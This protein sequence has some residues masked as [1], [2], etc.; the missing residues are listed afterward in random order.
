L[1]SAQQKR[2]LERLAREHENLRTTLRWFLEEGDTERA[3]RLGGALWWFWWI[4]GYVSEGKE[5]LAQVGA[6]DQQGEAW[7]RAKALH[8]AGTLAALQGRFDETERLCT[9]SLHLFKA[10][11]DARGSIPPLWMLGYI[12]KEQSAYDRARTL[13]EEGL[14]LS[15]HIGHTWG[16]AYSLETLAAV[17]FNQGHYQRAR[18]L[19]EESVA[20]SRKTGDTEGVSRA[21]WLQAL[22]IMAQ[23]DLAQARTLLSRSLALANEVDDKR[24]NAY[25]LVILGYVEIFNGDS[26]WARSFLEGGLSLFRELGD[27]RGIAWAL[28]GL[29]WIALAQGN[30]PAAQK[31]FEES[32]AGLR[33]LGHR[34]FMTLV[35]EGWAAALSAQGQPEHAARFWG[36]AE[37]LR[38]AIA[39]AL[40]PV[41]QRMYDPYLAAAREALGET[42][43]AAAWSEGRLMP[44]GALLQEPEPVTQERTPSGAVSSDG[45]SSAPLKFPSGLTL[46]EVEV[47][48]LVAAGLTDMQ[49][50]EK[51][52]ISARTVNTH[53][54]SIYSKLRITS[55]SAATR[56][57]VEQHLV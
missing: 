19:V 14:Q 32:L 24:N 41:V 31:L 33:A 17:A 3:L 15:R 26:A 4:R 46:R 27:R 22:V 37:G 5:F 45:S 20:V 38:H 54:T 53:L 36:A 57:A 34:W 2:W 6:A 49:V 56:F 47:L 11:G 51:L 9:E 7:V 55:R 8:A 35:L 39:A 40:P 1:T 25:A 28:Y 12:S 21:S 23:G 48:R 50:A 13:A 43:F 29:G 52:V 44:L 18:A 10:A 30:A 42:A 16:I